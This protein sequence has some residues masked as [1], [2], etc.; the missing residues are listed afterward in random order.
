MQEHSGHLISA[1]ADGSIAAEL[2]I[3]PGDR[4]LAIDGRT[5]IDVFDYRIRQLAQQIC[6]A[7]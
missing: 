3:E 1:V 7:D 4:L 6:A 5:V 2:G